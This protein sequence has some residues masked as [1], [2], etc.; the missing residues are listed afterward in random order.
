[1]PANGHTCPTCGAATP[2]KVNPELVFGAEHASIDGRSVFLTRAQ[3]V[4][5]EGLAR[6]PLGDMCPYERLHAYVDDHWAARTGEE[7]VPDT[8]ALRVHISRLR[9][10]LQRLGIT[11]ENVYG[12]GY[13]LVFHPLVDATPSLAE[14][15][16]G[17]PY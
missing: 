17:Q 15:D 3:M 7:D 13:R 14:P 2:W 4:V 9:G 12:R 8:A 11:I 1:M 16:H 10:A 5:A 6:P